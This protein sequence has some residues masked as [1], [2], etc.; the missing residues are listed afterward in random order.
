MRRY[1]EGHYED[2]ARTLTDFWA[3]SNNWLLYLGVPH[4]LA[5]HFADLFAT[6]CPAKCSVGSHAICL[7]EGF[8]RAKFLRDCGLEEE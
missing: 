8:D 2:V 1:S 4:K 5:E 6:D 3:D 7:T